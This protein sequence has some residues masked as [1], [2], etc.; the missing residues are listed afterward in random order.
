MVTAL[1]AI[2]LQGPTDH[3]SAS[4]IKAALRRIKMATARQA[5]AFRDIV[6]NSSFQSSCPEAH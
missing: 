6:F 4:S 5:I 3:N 2:A 1:Q